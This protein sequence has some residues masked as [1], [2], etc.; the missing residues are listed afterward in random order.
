MGSYPC[1]SGDIAGLAT[2][3][4][5][6]GPRALSAYPRSCAAQPA[7]AT[8]MAASAS[9]IRVDC[10]IRLTR[11]GFS[12]LQHM[13][14]HPA[15]V[16]VRQPVLRVCRSFAISV[17]TLRARPVPASIRC[18]AVVFQIAP[19]TAAAYG[20]CP[21]TSPP[22]PGKLAACR[23]QGS[24]STWERHVRGQAGIG[25]S[26]W[27]APKDAYMVIRSPLFVQI[28]NS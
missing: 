22:S 11:N 25:G 28:Q 20:C 16:P 7:I 15:W 5:D 26:S 6:P 10:M 1:R 23:L 9:V 12:L 21:D 4:T 24:V 2:G 14:C 27:C 3:W 8:A 18:L 17:A 13:P 19:A